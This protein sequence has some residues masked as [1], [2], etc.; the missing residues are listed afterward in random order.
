MPVINLKHLNVVIP[1][2]HFKLEGLQN[3][4]YFLHSIAFPYRKT[5][6]NTFGSVGE[7]TYTNS[8]AYVLAWV[9]SHECSQNY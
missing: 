5:R 6:R 8:C 3:L 4:R 9:L 2:N 7:E 1:Y